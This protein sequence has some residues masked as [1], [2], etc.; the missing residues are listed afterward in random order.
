[1]KVSVITCLIA[2]ACSGPS[3]MAKPPV[4]AQTAKA[5]PTPPLSFLPRVGGSVRGVIAQLEKSPRLQ[6]RYANHYGT[7]TTELMSF[8]RERLVDAEI[9]STRQYPIWMARPDGTRFAKFQTLK[10][11]ARVLA[12]RNGTPFLRATCGNPFTSHITY[13]K[14]KPTRQAKVKPMSE[15]RRRYASMVT[16]YETESGFLSEAPYEVPLAT[17]FA[18]VPYSVLRSRHMFLPLWWKTG[19][20]KPGVPEPSTLSFLALAALPLLGL[21]RRKS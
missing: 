19:G 1:V 17:S 2:A 7:T 20:S 15:M 3:A 13:T 10:K 4:R 5:T 12:L 18:D 11:G 6:A 9:P 8:F 21:R 16:P 14:R